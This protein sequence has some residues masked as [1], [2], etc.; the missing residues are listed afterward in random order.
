MVQGEAARATKIT[1]ASVRRSRPTSPSYIAALGIYRHCSIAGETP[2][3]DR[4]GPECTGTVTFPTP[5]VAVLLDFGQAAG[6]TSTSLATLVGR[7]IGSPYS[8]RVLRWP[9]I[10]SRM[11]RSV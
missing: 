10:A 3:S 2:L 5:T 1:N 4:T 9:S 8:A 6:E 11:L 7:G